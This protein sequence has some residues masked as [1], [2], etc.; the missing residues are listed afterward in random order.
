MLKRISACAL[1]LAASCWPAFAQADAGTLVI[2]QSVDVES[3][4]P[5]MLNQAT[6]INVASHLWGTLLSVTPQGEIVPNFAESYAWNDEGTE[7]SFKIRD[8]LMCEDGETLDAEDVVY[9]FT[10]AADP[11]NKFIGHTPGFV[12]SS[13]G[14]VGARVEEGNTAVMQLKGYSSTVPGMAA[15]IFIHCKDSYE[16]LTVEEAAVAPVASGPYKLVEWVRA[17]RVVLEKNPN[18]TLGE[19][20]FD[21]V[22]F[23]VVPESSTRTA[24]LIAGNV[25]IATNIPPDQ[26]D[27]IDSTGYAT[28]KS[29]A[30]TRRMFVGFNFSGAF[31]GT[32]GGDAI[33][34]VEVRRALNMAVDVPTI[35]QQLLGTEC[36]RANGPAN[37]GDPSIE[38]YPYDPDA[39]EAALDAAGFPRDANGVRFTLDM[40]GPQ[41]RYLNDSAVQQAIAQYL[42]DIGVET[43]NDLME[44]TLFSPLAREHKAGPLFFIG[45]GGATWSAIYDMSLFPS[46]D[47]PVNNGMWFNQ[48]WQT[49]WD[50][51]SGIRDPE[52]ERVVV[53]EMLKIFHDDAPW[54]FLYFQP[55]FYGVSSRIEWEPRR[56]EAIEAWTAKLK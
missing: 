40:Q 48:E 13:I 5:D 50:S 36:V 9:S 11:A 33:K 2:A 6:S 38:P 23:R 41:G 1:L 45:Q 37:L 55:D 44:M 53:D 28:V 27:A 14:F 25:D 30:G 34:N 8:G 16:K 4:E 52:A 56:D 32:P 46:R 49:R 21:K 18:W 10:R 35:C 7:I 17:D 12:Y 15:K 54:I 3:L 43:T 19:V 47:V 22:I 39:A 29:V 51:L 26:A 31:D 20:P 42:S 24:E